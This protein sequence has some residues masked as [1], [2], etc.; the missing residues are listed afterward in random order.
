MFYFAATR[1]HWVGNVIEDETVHTAPWH[2]GL[3]S[4]TE[5]SRYSGEPLS[6]V[7]RWFHDRNAA[8]RDKLATFDDLVSL[9][10]VRELRRRRIPLK[11]IR[12]AED[13]LVQRTGNS[14]P[15]VHESL[16]VSGRDV[17]VRV[18]DAP[19]AF[20]SPNRRGQLAIP[21]VTQPDRVELP[22]L[23][24]AVRGEVAY[25]AGRVVEWRPVDRITARAEI[26]FGLTCNDATR[27]PTRYLYG[28]YGEGERIEDIAHLFRVTERDVSQAIEWEQRLA[29]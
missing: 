4:E 2:L 23:V 1:P 16:W 29:A 19:S 18:S 7:H 6:T 27:V 15:F 5:A 13:D 28:L 3:Y 26:Q 12:D 22:R 10:F 20:L 25:S 14:H 17:L 9:L 11:A 8:S 24:P 21:G